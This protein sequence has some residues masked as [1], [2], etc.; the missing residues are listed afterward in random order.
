MRVSKRVWS[1]GAVVLVLGAMGVAAAQPAPAA[2]GG[3]DPLAPAQATQTPE[4]MKT[5]SATYLPQ[6]EQG[7]AGV[8][9]QVEEA[10]AARDVVKL[11]CLNDKLTQLDVATRTAKD[12]Y[13]SFMSASERGDLER[14]RHEFTVL[15]VL[16]DRARELVAEAQQCIGEETGFLGESRVTVE[17]P[18]G[19][20]D[21]AIYPEN[22]III[23]IPPTVSSPI[24]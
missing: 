15:Q 13:A 22:S 9:R 8:R 16:R 10:R 17:V 7:A 24:R 18:P 6:M 1:V 11:Q 12:R 4:Q 14:Q 20:P 23:S 3:P 19:L 21:P 2:T 5:E